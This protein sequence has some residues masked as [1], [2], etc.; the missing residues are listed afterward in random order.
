MRYFILINKMKIQ[1][2][3]TSIKI[4]ASYSSSF[5]TRILRQSPREVFSATIEMKL[6][7]K[8]RILCAFLSFSSRLLSISMTLS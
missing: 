5:S 3:E 4:L 7:L 8:S 6:N 2:A 1:Q